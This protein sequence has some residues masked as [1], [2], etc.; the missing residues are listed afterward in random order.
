VSER[1]SGEGA[2]S[3]L[4]SRGRKKIPQK[5]TRKLFWWPKKHS[6]S[7]LNFVIEANKENEKKSIDFIFLPVIRKAP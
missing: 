7:G 4:T 6:C 5:K 2:S 1:R 3:L